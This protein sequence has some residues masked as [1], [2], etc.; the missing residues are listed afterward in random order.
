MFVIG[1]VLL[2]LAA[3]ISATT[4]GIKTEDSSIFTAQF[5]ACKTQGSSFLCDPSGVL[6]SSRL[7]TN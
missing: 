2:A 6:N 7:I 1:T 4:H 5:D 3:A